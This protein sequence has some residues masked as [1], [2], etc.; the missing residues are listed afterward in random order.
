MEALIFDTET[1]GFPLKSAWSDPAQPE[2]MQIAAIRMDSEFNIRRSFSTIICVPEELEISEGA[3]NVHGITNEISQEHGID[4]ADALE[5]FGHMAVGA[6]TIIAHN[7]DFDSKML[8]IAYARADCGLK[9]DDWF[10]NVGKYCTMKGYM[11]HLGKTS[12]KG[13]GLDTAYRDLVDPAG[14]EGAHDAYADALAC[15]KV[16]KSLRIGGQG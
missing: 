14:F 13:C 9:A 4:L 11:R 3:L 2:L 1:S 5:I 8:Q 16:Y 6:D 15:A 10:N 7:L 12:W